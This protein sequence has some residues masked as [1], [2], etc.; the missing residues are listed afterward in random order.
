MLLA[1]CGSPRNKNTTFMLRTVLEKVGKDKELLLLME[2]NIKFCDGCCSCEQTGRCHIKD[3]MESVIKNLQRVDSVLIG[4][5]TYYDNVPALLKNFID[6]TNPLFKDLRLKDKKVG[7]AVTG[8]ASFDSIDHALDVLRWFAVIHKMT[9][10]GS[11]GV[12]DK[13][14]RSK[15][16]I[17]ELHKLGEKLSK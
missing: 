10:V 8:E 13:H 5:P 16:V 9:I 14:I 4:T 1:I 6:R 11:V 15:E 17:D 3:D 12:M 2:K 7:F